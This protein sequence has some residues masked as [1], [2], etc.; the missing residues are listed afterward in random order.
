M[1]SFELMVSPY[2]AHATDEVGS[3]CSWS[4]HPDMSSV[5]VQTP[6]YTRFADDLLGPVLMSFVFVFTNTQGFVRSWLQ[7]KF[8]SSPLYAAAGEAAAT[9]S[10]TAH[11]EAATS[12]DTPASEQSGTNASNGSGSDR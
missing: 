4:S 6:N 2:H 7:R 11:A 1:V 8:S 5:Y 9:A 3:D 12:P 10:A